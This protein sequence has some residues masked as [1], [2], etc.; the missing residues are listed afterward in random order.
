MKSFKSTGVNTGSLG[1]QIH[2]SWR[3]Q[4]TLAADG[5]WDALEALQFQLGWWDKLE[6]LSS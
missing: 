2:P 6:S 5:D 1:Q 4:V 3:Q